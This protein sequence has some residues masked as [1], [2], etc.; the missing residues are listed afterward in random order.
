MCIGVVGQL[1]V[2]E[3]AQLTSLGGSI[4]SDIHSMDLAQTGGDAI[5]KMKVLF[6]FY[7]SSLKMCFKLGFIYCP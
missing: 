2:E 4:I 3:G 7:A 6:E 1:S 5:T